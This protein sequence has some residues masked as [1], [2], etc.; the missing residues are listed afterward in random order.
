VKNFLLGVVVG[1]VG[2]LWYAQT[3][4]RIDIDRQFG[5]MQ[6]RA[7]AVLTESRR[8]LEETRQE[9]ASALESGRQSVQQKTERL[10]NPSAGETGSTGASEPNPPTT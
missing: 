3:K 2:A 6:E 8:I 4:G 9:L 1:A 5:Q 7:N 10:R